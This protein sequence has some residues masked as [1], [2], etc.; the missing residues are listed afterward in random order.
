[1]EVRAPSLAVR[2]VFLIIAGTA[3]I[4][5][6]YA[7]R[8]RTKPAR[9]ALTADD[10]SRI[11][12]NYDRIVATAPVPYRPPQ[13]MQQLELA[14]LYAHAQQEL[15][16]DG[17]RVAQDVI[18]SIAQSDGAG[19]YIRAVL[20]TNDG[21]FVRWAAR[22]DPI[23]VWIQSPS[24]EALEY[25][26]RAWNG[27]NAGVTYDIVDDSTQADVWVTWSPTLLTSQELGVAAR[28]M[29][30]D[31]RLVYV[32]VIL[33]ASGDAGRQQN[34]AMHEA[35]HAL[36]LDHSTDQD[37]IMYEYNTGAVLSAADVRTLRL[38]Y[39]LPFSHY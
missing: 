36:G 25:G 16:G 6:L 5:T 9:P 28:Q 12:Q 37:D 11:L 10:S 27:A 22:Q 38:L 39:R 32:N 7:I 31:G 30:A 21:R 19:T 8:R 26:F 1:M 17:K 4:A 3:S 24:S 23:H 14:K 18:D 34:T 15:E 20:A 13:W 33:L 35:G 2:L 29:D